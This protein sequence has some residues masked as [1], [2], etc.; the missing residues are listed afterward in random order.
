MA[1]ADPGIFGTL[2]RIPEVAIDGPAA[3]DAQLRA[4]KGPFVVRELVAD[5]P[6][7]QAGKSSA[8]EARD[9]IARRRRDRPFTVSVGEAGSDGRMFYDAAMAMNFRTMRAKLPE[10]FAKID[11]LGDEELPIYL[12][13]IDLHEYFDGLHEANHVDLGDRVTL[14]SIWMGTRTRIAAHNDI[15]DNLACVA[16]GRRRFTLFPH[17]QFRNLYLGPIDNTPAGRAVSMVDFHAPDLG[18]HPRFSEALAHAQVAE[19]AAGDALYIPAMWWHHVEGLDP[20]NVLVNYW[21]RETPRWL[22]Q[23][24][25]A[26]N[27]AILAIRDL[28]DDA[29]A[30]WRDLF[31]YYVF[32]NGD[33]VTAHIPEEGR[34]ILAPLN[35]ETAGRIRA[36]LLRQLSQ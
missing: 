17:E 8:R 1:E 4:A 21:W 24:Q 34:S 26:L 12:A 29:K 11:E 27:H 6:L 20:F 32:G 10:I 23:P 5:W 31:D 28:P 16:V 2:A 18:A 15:P 35:P 9:Y 30:R 22:G 14:D 25:D 3:L 19:L 13:S 7:V 33:D 36:F